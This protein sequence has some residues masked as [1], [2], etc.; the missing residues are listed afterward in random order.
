MAY[1]TGLADR[2]RR[3]LASLSD[4][5]EVR[6]FGGLCFMVG[7][8]MCC[9]VLKDDLVVRLDRADVPGALREPHVRPMDFTGRPARGLVYVGAP[10]TRTAAGVRRWVKRAVAHAASLPPKAGGV[11]R[12]RR[13]PRVKARRP[14]TRAAGR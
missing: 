4:V 10:G 13:P 8:H 12:R 5:R 7:G 11:R 9:G 3:E 1:D 6:M 14:P 2:I